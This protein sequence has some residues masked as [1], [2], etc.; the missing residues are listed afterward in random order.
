MGSQ[1]IGFVRFAGTGGSFCAAEP[2]HGVFAFVPRPV[3]PMTKS[4][5]RPVSAKPELWALG[6]MAAG[7]VFPQNHSC[8]TLKKAIR[9]K[10][11]RR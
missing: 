7:D 11:L 2:R 1:W 9:S 3:V 8:G 6:S 10:F 4:F 5:S